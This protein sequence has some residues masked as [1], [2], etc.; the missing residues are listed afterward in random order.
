[1]DIICGYRW[2]FDAVCMRVDVCVCVWGG[3]GEL[4][5][6]AFSCNNYTSMTTAMI[7]G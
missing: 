4:L 1:M 6:A 7:A 5:C 3:G 2:V